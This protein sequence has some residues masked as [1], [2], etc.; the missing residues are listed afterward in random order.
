MKK[1]KSWSEQPEG[2][3]LVRAASR[4]GLLFPGQ[5]PGDWQGRLEL[6]LQLMSFLSRT[7]SLA[8]QRR[9]FVVIVPY[10]ATLPS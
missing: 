2:E 5:P 7:F 1:V 6:L 4:T 3:K 8:S 10:L 9:E